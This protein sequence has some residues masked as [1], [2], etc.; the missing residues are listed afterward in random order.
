MAENIQIQKADST[1]SGR[2]FANIDGDEA[3]MAYT[4]PGPALFST[5]HTF[6]PDSMRG[7][8]VAQ[9]LALN[10]VEDHRNTLW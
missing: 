6:V 5:D 4:K 1:D 3:D 7:K 8:G 2:Y 9:V 10:S